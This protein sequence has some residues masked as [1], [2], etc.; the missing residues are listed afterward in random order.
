MV[1]TSS[2]IAMGIAV[3]WSFESGFESYVREREER[4]AYYRDW[5]NRNREKML[6]YNAEYRANNRDR[7]R[8]YSKDWYAK[9]KE[10]AAT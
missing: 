5:Y 6:V 4:R 1:Y 8:Q 7:I 3:R 10:K 2:A 9:Q